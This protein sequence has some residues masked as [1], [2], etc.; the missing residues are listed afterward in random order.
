M[1]SGEPRGS[2]QQ[3]LLSAGPARLDPLGHDLDGQGAQP[4][5]RPAEHPQHRAGVVEH[6]ALARVERRGSGCTDDGTTKDEHLGI[7]PRRSDSRCTAPTAPELGAQVV[8]GAAT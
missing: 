1:W 2:E 6:R 5:A 3:A 8:A 4:R 7:P